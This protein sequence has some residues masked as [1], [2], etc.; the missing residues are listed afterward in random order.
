MGRKRLPEGEKKIAITIRLPESVIQKL[1][2][3]GSPRKLIE[4]IITEL[5]RKK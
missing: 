2:S 1:Q 5:F 4:N 3:M